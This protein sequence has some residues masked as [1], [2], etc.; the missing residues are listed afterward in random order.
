MAAP[1]NG[2]PDFFPGTAGKGPNHLTIEQCLKSAPL[3]LS[4]GSL[5]FLAGCVVAA[6][7]LG[8]AV[9]RPVAQRIV[10]LLLLGLVAVL[11]MSG[12]YLNCTLP[13]LSGGGQ[14]DGGGPSEACFVPSVLCRP[15]PARSMGT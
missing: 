14:G 6:L 7:Y 3:S 2:C 15:L 4:L 9:R 1:V 12:L 5:L 11:I 13:V 8:F 10:V